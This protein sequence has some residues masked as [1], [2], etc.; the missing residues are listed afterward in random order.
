MTTSFRMDKILK[1]LIAVVLLYVLMYMNRCDCNPPN[2]Q[3]FEK[4]RTHPNLQTF[5]EPTMHQLRR[6]LQNDK[7]KTSKPGPALISEND[8]KKPSKP[9]PALISE[10]S[11]Q[12]T[13]YQ[14]RRPLEYDNNKR[15]TKSIAWI[16]NISAN[17]RS[18]Y[19]QFGEDG[20]LEYIFQQVPD[21]PKSFF[22]IGAHITEANTLY[23]REKGWKGWSIDST[24]ESSKLNFSAF[25]VR[26]N[27]IGA[28][29]EHLDIPERIGLLSVDIDSFDYFLL[30]QIL[31]YRT[32]DLLLL[33]FNP[34]WSLNQKYCTP[35]D[36]YLRFHCDV[37]YGNSLR[38][39][40][41][42]LK[43]PEYDYHLIAISGV[44]HN[45]FF[46]KGKYLSKDFIASNSMNKYVQ[47]PVREYSAYK[48]NTAALETYS[49]VIQSIFN[50]DNPIKL[51]SCKEI[52][53]FADICKKSPRGGRYCSTEVPKMMKQCKEFPLKVWD[54]P[55]FSGSCGS[56]NQAAPSR[57]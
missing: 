36:F 25:Y 20:M 35:P 31:S 23:F 21:I 42:L 38:S 4:P 34:A 28:F 43:Q 52:K 22:E 11:W 41:E 16:S 56:G 27:N 10:R 47:L 9:G 40:F 24:S 3:T 44:P 18:V 17:K 37:C 1:F 51:I 49:Q 19:S 39:F 15:S 53:L 54:G 5:D 55:M 12:G 8:K 14:P 50:C 29:M 48:D 13:N 6:P 7:K 30:K 57:I 2:L 32:A 45:A 33:E 26:M 46:L